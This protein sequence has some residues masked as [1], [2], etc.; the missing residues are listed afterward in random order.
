MEDR[1]RIKE[2]IGVREVE[3]FESYLGLPALVGCAKYQTFSFFKDRVWKKKFRVGRNNYCQE[4]GRK[5]L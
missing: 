3:R 2:T 5:F 4:L 1:E